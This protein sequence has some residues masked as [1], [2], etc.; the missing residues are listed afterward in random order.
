MNP[1]TTWDRLLAAYAAG[2]W[3]AIEQNATSLK[4]WLD[5]GGR[6][7]QILGRDDV[8]PD[9]DRALA[10]AGCRFALET[11]HGSWALAVPTPCTGKQE[12]S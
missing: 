3:D 12:R 11:L 8:G 10:Q 1:Q 5:R 9:W 4:E 2:D 6:P 7:P